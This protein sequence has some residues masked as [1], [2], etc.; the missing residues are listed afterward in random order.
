MMDIFELY[1]WAQFPIM[2]IALC[3][4]VKYLGSRFD[5]TNARLLYIATLAKLVSPLP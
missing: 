1:A 2:F 3:F 5:E 4:A